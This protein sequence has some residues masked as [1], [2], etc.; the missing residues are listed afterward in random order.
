MRGAPAARASS[1]TRVRR[2]TLARHS[3]ERDVS[4][5]VPACQRSRSSS[6][7]PSCRRRRR[8]RRRRP[9]SP[10]ISSAAAPSG[11]TSARIGRSAARYSN[12]LPLSTPLPRPPA[13][14][15]SSRSASES[16]WSSSER[17]R[18]AYGISSRR[19]PSRAAPAHSRSVERK[20]P[21]KRATHRRGPTRASAV[22]NGRG[23]RL[24]KNE[25]A[26]VIRKRSPGGTRARRSRRS[27]S[28]SRS[29]R[30]ARAECARASPR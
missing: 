19:S 17:R 6:A 18:G 28:R 7:Q 10:R 29:S 4:A 8:A 12:T 15:I 9:R 25:P 27:R 20:S 24:P 2:D 3:S 23:S 13:S 30:P 26:W 16:R 5:S 11:G 22:R 1:S 21:R 14:G